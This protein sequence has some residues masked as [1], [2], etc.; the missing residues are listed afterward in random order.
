MYKII[1]RDARV[2]GTHLQG[3]IVATYDE[4]VEK[5][6]EPV[7]KGEEAGGFDKVWTE[8][9]IEFENS[10]GDSVIATIYDWKE[11]SPFTSRTGAYNWH[12]GGMSWEATDAI[13]SVLNN[14]EAQYA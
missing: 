8:W 13:N 10:D 5:F 4:L 7:Y 9:A 12:V 6:G 1:D 2:S 11:S 14:K 3:H